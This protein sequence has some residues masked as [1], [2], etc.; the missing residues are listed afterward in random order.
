MTYF[1]YMDEYMR[2][3]EE[4]Y[5]RDMDRT[6]PP[7]NAPEDMHYMKEDYEMTHFMSRSKYTESKETY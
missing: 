2:R 5:F 1:N 3:W 4:H 7:F 6:K